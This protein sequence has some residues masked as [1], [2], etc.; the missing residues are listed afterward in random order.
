MSCAVQLK[1]MTGDLQL[2][3]KIYILQ[4]PP[5]G[6]TNC[7]TAASLM[8]PKIVQPTCLDPN[9]PSVHIEC[10]LQLTG[11]ML[12]QLWSST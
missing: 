11:Q 2:N 7:W 6:T 5:F 3:R 8:E 4:R 12:R 10:Q 1:M 9:A